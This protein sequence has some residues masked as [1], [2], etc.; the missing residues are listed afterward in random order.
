MRTGRIIKIDTQKMEASIFD[1]IA[2]MLDRGGMIGYPTETV[3][4]LGGDATNEETVRRI[5][6]LKDRAAEL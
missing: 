2:E 4:G 3:Y 5:S 1:R 6:E